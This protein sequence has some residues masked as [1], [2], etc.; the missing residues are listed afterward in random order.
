MTAFGN[1]ITVLGSNS[2]SGSTFCRYLIEQGH[3]V[4]AISRSP[5]APEVLCPYRAVKD[6]DLEFHQLD[7]NQDLGGVLALMDKYKTGRI[8]NFAAQS[9]VAESWQHPEHWFMT[10]VVSTVKLH[11]SLLQRDYLEKYIHITTPEVYGSTTGMV[12]E[13]QPFNPSTPYAV[14]RAAADMSLRTF[15]TT[16]GF[17]YVGTRA[18]NVFGP[19]Q[20]LYRIVPKSIYSILKGLNIPLHGGGRS[21]RSFIDIED[22]CRATYLVGERGRYGETY[23]IATQRLISI[24]ELVREICVQMEVDFDQAV[25]VVGERTGKDAAYYL[26]TSK[27]RREL[28]WADEIPLEMGVRRTIAWAHRYEA[29]LESL[30]KQYQHKP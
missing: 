18:A 3:S 20:P 7:L 24:A 28:G 4:L 16:H 26:D 10:N 11:Q 23:H 13:S 1:R 5:Q 21:V 22:V 9:M 25:D 29:D 27:I 2:F 30:P 15:F 12:N 17:P 8:Y 6:A 14:S 19:G